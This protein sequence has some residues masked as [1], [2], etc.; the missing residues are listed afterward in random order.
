MIEE[1]VLFDEMN[2]EIS[3]EMKPNIWSLSL[4][5]FDEMN[6]EIS[7]EMKE[8]MVIESEGPPTGVHLKRKVKFFTVSGLKTK[9]AVYCIKFNRFFDID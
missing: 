9:H 7:P 6:E 8:Y 3:P 1:N 4:V 2:E 5:L